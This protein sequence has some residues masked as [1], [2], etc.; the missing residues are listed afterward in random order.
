MTVTKQSYS[1]AAPWTVANLA[2]AHRSAFIDAGL[3]TEWHDSFTAANGSLIRVLRIVHDAT[4]TW[5]TCFYYLIFRVSEPVGVALA[6][7]WN[8]STH[9]PTGTQ[10][11]DYHT[12]PTNISSII[13]SYY[14]T[15]MGSFNPSTTSNAVLHRYTSGADPN[16]S[17]FVFQQNTSRTQP[18]AFL[19]ASTVLHSWLDLNKGMIS[20]FIAQNAGIS[21]SS[22]YV[23][24]YI[25]ENLKRC[26]VYGSAL[27][28]DNEATFSQGRFHAVGISTQCYGG[29]GYGSNTT[30][31]NF[32]VIR[33]DVRAATALPV[34]RSAVNPAYTAD[35]LPIC[36]G[37]PYSGY[38]STPLASDFGIYMHFADNTMAFQDKFIVTT[39]VEEWE[40]LNTVNNSVLTEYASPNF[41]A[42]TV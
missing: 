19:H 3:M 40:I 35:Y 21:N 32:G 41:L 17:W 25:Q 23:N 1:L 7:G 33:G 39:G 8:V 29:I 24:F 34:G 38:T 15:T 10:F 31:N 12:L 14:N 20:G 42:R 28:G 13:N 37:L 16:Q 6:S 2:D 27:R 30:T 11:L 18:I 26:L 5:G 36:T 9:V 4:K 22:A